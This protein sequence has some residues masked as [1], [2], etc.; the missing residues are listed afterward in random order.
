MEPRV[1]TARLPPFT[2]R[3]RLDV[4]IGCAGKAAGRLLITAALLQKNGPAGRSAPGCRAPRLP[5]RAAERLQAQP[6]ALSDA[7]G[8]LAGQRLLG[9]RG[10][11][12]RRGL[13]QRQVYAGS[14][15]GAHE[16]RHD[17]QPELTERPAADEHRGTD[18]AR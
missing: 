14:R 3:Y 13:A 2:I 11:Q 6:L 4:R 7:L 1:L 16:R 12:Q 9:F 18:A 5:R 15:R 10:S 8:L 17:E